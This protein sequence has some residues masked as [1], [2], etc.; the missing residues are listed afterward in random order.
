MTLSIESQVVEVGCNVRLSGPIVQSVIGIDPVYQDSVFGCVVSGLELVA[1]IS[2]L[3]A[4][5][6][7]NPLELVEIKRTYLI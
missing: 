1:E 6:N 2:R 3:P 5:H 7:A 4:D